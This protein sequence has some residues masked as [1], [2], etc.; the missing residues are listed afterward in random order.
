[1]RVLAE[2]SSQ[3]AAVWLGFAEIDSSVELSL[4]R[5]VTLLQR[6]EHGVHRRLHFR[7]GQCS[8]R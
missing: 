7:V 5:G 2:R 4:N 8:V 3:N 1:M 6:G